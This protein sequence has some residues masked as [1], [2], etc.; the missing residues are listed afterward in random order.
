MKVVQ[1]RRLAIVARAAAFLLPLFLL[2][3]APSR[4]AD[5][6]PA[7]A[8]TGAEYVG[9]ETCLQC[10]TTQANQFAHTRHARAFRENPKNAL[11][12]RV[13]EACHGPGSEH[14][15]D[16]LNRQALIGFTKAWGTPVAIQ[17]ATCLGCHNGG[18]RLH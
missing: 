18:E 8:M 4:A 10:H 11:E 9:Q 17:N 15:K 7:P 13:C 16:P 2:H 3:P 5:E 12:A 1:T 14:A 6:A